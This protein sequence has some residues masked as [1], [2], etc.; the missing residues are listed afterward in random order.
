M[1]K[2]KITMKLK[3][4][5]SLEITSELTPFVIQISSIAEKDIKAYCKFVYTYD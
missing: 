3:V 2:K 4:M 1:K 5:I